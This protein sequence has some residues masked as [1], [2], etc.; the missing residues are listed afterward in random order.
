M[1]YIITEEQEKRLVKGWKVNEGQL[2]KTFNFGTYKDVLKF[3]NKVG[4][5]AEKQNHHP[6]MLVKYNS[7]KV[8]LFDHEANKVSDKCHNLA[9]LINKI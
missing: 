6:D 3:V 7:V 5:I 4:L 9:H 2:T 8:S 1:Y